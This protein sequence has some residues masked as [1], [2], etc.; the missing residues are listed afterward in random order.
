MAKHL[1]FTY[2][3]PVICL[4]IYMYICLN[5]NIFPV[6]FKDSFRNYNYN[7]EMCHS[8]EINSVVLLKMHFNFSAWSTSQQNSSLQQGPVLSGCLIYPGL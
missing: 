7:F 1:L 5:I 3:Y 6:D 8:I 4:N 2:L